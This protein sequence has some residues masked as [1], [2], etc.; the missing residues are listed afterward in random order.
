MYRESSYE[1]FQPACYFRRAKISWRPDQPL[2]SAFDF[3]NE[4]IAQEVPAQHLPALRLC[5]RA[6]RENHEGDCQ[7]Y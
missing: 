7:Q 2:S 1:T 3:R 4:A 5:I 6:G